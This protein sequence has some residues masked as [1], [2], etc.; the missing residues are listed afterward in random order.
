MIFNE[1]ALIGPYVIDIEVHEDNRGYFGR[2]WCR[3]EFDAQGLVPCMVQ[4]NVSF[5]HTRG[6]LRGMHY[7][8]EPCQEVKLVRCVRGRVFDVIIDIRPDS[9][10]FKQ[11]IGVEL[12][13]DNRRMLYVP[14][15][16]AHG[17]QTLEDNSE[18]NYL[19]SE[20]YAPDYERGIR[21]DDPAF[22][23]EW[24]ETE[25]RVISD[26]DLSWPDF[27]SEGFHF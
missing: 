14:R 15:G 19:V 2:A 23:V 27:P 9:A 22:G 1:T 20:F 10:T 17:F 26:K 13:A 21:H 5:N 16:F 25:A 8:T 7:Q 4:G 6:T 11:W 12:S 24:P 3:H 18:V